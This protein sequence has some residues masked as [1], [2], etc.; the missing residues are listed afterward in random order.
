MNFIKKI[1]GYNKNISVPNSHKPT[2]KKPPIKH[3]KIIEC[4]LSVIINDDYLSTPI[5]I[6]GINIEDEHH[7]FGTLYPL[8]YV[9]NEELN[10]DGQITFSMSINGRV[11]GSMLEEIIP[12]SNSDFPEIRDEIMRVL[13]QIGK[14]NIIELSETMSLHPSQW[15]KN[16]E[17]H[18]LI[19]LNYHG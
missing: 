16:Y 4:I 8:T 14:K 9:W 12:R 15:L 10:H 3:K 19:N 17:Y 1:L 18:E 7:E 6:H 13:N 5:Y 2:Q 11:V